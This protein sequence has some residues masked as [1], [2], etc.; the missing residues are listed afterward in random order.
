MRH[1]F[2]KN[3]LANQLWILDELTKSW[4]WQGNLEEYLLNEFFDSKVKLEK[5]KSIL[6]SH[7]GQKVTH[8][9]SF[10]M[11]LKT[12]LMHCVKPTVYICYFTEGIEQHT[13]KMI[14]YANNKKTGKSQTFSFQQ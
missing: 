7:E 10:Y 4:Y 3:T 12:K 9:N 13:I 6:Q 5:F 8:I 14:T 2:K 11:Q 1:P